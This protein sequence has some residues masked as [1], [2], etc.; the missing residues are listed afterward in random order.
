MRK[1]PMLKI[2]T[3]SFI[4]SVDDYMRKYEEKKRKEKEN[5]FL[6][7]DTTLSAALNKLP[8]NWIN[9]IC[10]KLDIPVEGRKRKK[11]KEIAHKLKENLKGVTE[12]LPSDSLDAITF[13]LERD[14]WVKSGAITRRFG[15]EDPGWFWEKHPPEGTIGVLR[16]H[17]LVF[18]GRAGFS[19]RRYKIFSIPVELREELEEIL[20]PES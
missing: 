9:A 11:G 7:P 5:Q 20:T 12:K 17:G 3:S 10:R 1:N 4:F 15:K 13:I 16:V 6:K 18:V 2:I 14:G 19:G 8:A